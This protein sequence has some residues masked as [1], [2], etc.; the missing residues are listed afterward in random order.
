M[1]ITLFIAILYIDA[2]VSSQFQINVIYTDLQPFIFTQADGTVDGI[3]PL[4]LRQGEKIC[5]NTGNI[6]YVNKSD[7]LNK[8]QQIGFSRKASCENN[9]LQ[10]LSKSGVF[11]S[12]FVTS[13]GRKP[14]QI[15]E[16]RVIHEHELELI[17]T[18]KV[19]V[20]IHRSNIP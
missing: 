11:I 19:V 2:E 20:I 14:V 10:N 15:C 5:N 12:P 3:I 9:G 7:L 18:T 16:E 6:S 13:F 1:S 8:L 4:Q 17:K